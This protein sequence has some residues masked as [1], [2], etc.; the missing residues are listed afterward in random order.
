MPRDEPMAAPAGRP[1]SGMP[2]KGPG[3]LAIVYRGS[4]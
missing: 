3:E 1:M 2:A 4:V